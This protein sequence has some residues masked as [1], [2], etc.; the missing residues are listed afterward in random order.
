MFFLRELGGKVI[1]VSIFIVLFIEI[2]NVGVLHLKE[3]QDIKFPEA[4]YIRYIGE[5]V[6]NGPGDDEDHD[7][8]ERMEPNTR[9]SPDAPFRMIV[10][11]TK[12]SSIRLVQAQYL[13]SDI[14]FKRIVGFKEFELGGLDPDSRT[15]KCIFYVK[16]GVTK[17]YF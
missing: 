17:K 1:L 8:N 12:E 16:M 15:S 3:Q 4:P 13:Q 2:S 10:C 11:M 5:V 6:D 14:G 9:N 7:N